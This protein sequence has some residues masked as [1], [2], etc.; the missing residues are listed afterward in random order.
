MARFSKFISLAR[1][2]DEMLDAEMPIPGSMPEFPPG[3]RISLCDIELDKLEEQ[4]V[5]VAGIEEG[6][7][8]DVRFLAKVTWAKTTGTGRRIEMQATEI[9][10]EV[11]DD[12]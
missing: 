11:E 10:I 6:D 8:I 1:T 2:D 4:N 9:A 12:E 7:T 3:C 5:D